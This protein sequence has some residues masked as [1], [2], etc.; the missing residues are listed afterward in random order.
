MPAEASERGAVPARALARQFLGLTAEWDVDVDGVRLRMWTD[1]A[2]PLPE[3]L[4]VRAARSNWV[5]DDD[6][7]RVAT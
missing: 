6:P 4:H 7:E 5:A 1:P 2:R 3:T